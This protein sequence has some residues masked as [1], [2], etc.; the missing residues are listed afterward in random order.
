[1][2][3]R[4]H[5]GFYFKKKYYIKYN[6]QDSYPKALGITLLKE[7]LSNKVI[8]DEWK[9]KLENIKIVDESIKPDLET[10]INLNKYTNLMVSQ[11][12]LEDWE[13]LLHFT[14]GSFV[15]LLN[16]GYLINDSTSN[17]GLEVQTYDGEYAYILDLDHN[18]FILYETNEEEGG[19]EETKRISLTKD[20]LISLGVEWGWNG[21]F[22]NYDPDKELKKV[23]ECMEQIFGNNASKFFPTIEQ[24]KK[25]FASSEDKH[26]NI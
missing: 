21:N 25:I 14:Q 20:E 19:Y 9:Q 5:F 2:G 15:H 4:G 17:E 18:Q 1:M 22:D 6:H 7:M 16:S 3:T 11:R 8:F 24:I 23:R 12:S 13:C 10:I 26:I